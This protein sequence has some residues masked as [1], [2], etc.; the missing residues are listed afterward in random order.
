MAGGAEGPWPQPFHNSKI[1]MLRWKISGLF[2][3]VKTKTSN[4]IRKSMNLALLLYKYH[5]A[6]EQVMC[7]IGS[8]EIFLNIEGRYTEELHAIWLF[9]LLLG[10][11]F[12][13]F[14]LTL[15]KNLQPC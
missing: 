13:S 8:R 2:L 5:E 1:F 11:Q 4:F 6:P 10:C 9:L 7:S 15:V 3:L 12:S 14:L